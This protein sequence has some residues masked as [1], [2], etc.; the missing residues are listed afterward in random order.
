VAAQG[1][2]PTTTTTSQT[3]VTQDEVVL[4][5]D[6][7]PRPALPTIYGD[8]GF[9]HL[10]TA[11]TLPSKRMSFSLFRAN[12][13]LRQGLTD[14]DE[15]GL[16]GAV[17]FGRAELFASWGIVR[18]DRDVHPTFVP[19]D[20]AYGGVAQD[21]PYMRR[22]WSK[23]LG[24]PLLVGTKFNFISQSR[25]DAMAVALRLTGSFPIGADWGGT[26]DMVGRAE[27]VTSREFGKKFEATGTM[28]GVF[29]AD[30]DEFD[31]SDGI[32]WGIGA[33]F[34]SRSRVSGLAEWR[35]EWNFSQSLRSL[36][37]YVAEDGTVAPAVSFIDD[38]HHF[39]VGL[40]YQA[41]GGFFFHTGLNFTPG[42]TDR[43]VGANEINHSGWGWDVRLGW[44]PGVTQ[45]RERVHMIKET[46]TVTNTVTPPPPPPP[47]AANRNPTFSLN[48]TCDPAVVDPGGVS[49]CNATATDPDGDAVTYR[50]AAPSGTFGTPTTAGTTWTAT[51]NPGNVPLTVTAADARGG[52]ATSTV[53]VQVTRRVELVFEDVHFEFDRFNLRPKP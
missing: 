49:R 42:V 33:R 16:T 12:W 25:G 14:A 52:T 53:T 7:T 5:G 10:P 27:L 17:G 15:I 32:A 48:A 19:S 45:S 18:L 46:T 6:A 41:N 26:N 39:N 47:P 11:E 35:G 24:S 1:P 51:Q 2:A 38:P 20:S 22:G 37:P 21:F 28:G 31:L 40:V 30:P 50:W 34:P 29:R 43:M 44:H 13:D 36:T 3:A 23:N 8:T 4:Q 9:W